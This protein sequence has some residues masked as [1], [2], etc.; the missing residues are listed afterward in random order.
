MISRCSFSGFALALT[1]LVLPDTAIAANFL[2][3]NF[4][5]SGPR[6]EGVLPTCE[7]PSALNRISAR[8]GEKER[9]FWNSALDIKGFEKIQETAFRPWGSNAIPRRFCS[10]IIHVSDGSKHAIHYSIGEDSGMIGMT[11][12]VDWCV[13]GLDREWAYDP[14]CKMSRP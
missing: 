6:Y 4:W 14:A 10:A 7:E 12:G 3:M 1:F 2:E 13:V 11:W 8:F 5:L 9:A